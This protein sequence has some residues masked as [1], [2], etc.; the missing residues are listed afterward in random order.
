LSHRKK[1]PLAVIVNGSM[2]PVPAVGPKKNGIGYA[3]EMISNGISS[4]EMKTISYYDDN[5]DTYHFDRKK[6]IQIKPKFIHKLLFNFIF[7]IPLGIPKKLFGFSIA[8]RKSY[9]HSIGNTLKELEPDIIISQ[10]HYF[11]FNSLKK[12]YPNAKHVFH[13]RGSDMHEWDERRV[14][15]LFEKSDGIVTVC[16]A[17]MNSI[18]KKLNI[19]HEN[20]IVIPNAIDHKIFSKN[21]SIDRIK[22]IKSILSINLTDDIFLYA[23]RIHSS[24]G[25]YEVVEA[26]QMLKKINDKITLLIVGK[27]LSQYDDFELVEFLNQ[28][29]EN[30]SKTKIKIIETVDISKMA[31][32]YS[33][34]HISLSCSLE[35]EG[36]SKVIIE[37]L[38]SN[39]PVIVTD[40]GGN[41]EL[42]KHKYNGLIV[43]NKNLRKGLFNAMELIISDHK[44]YSHLA[45]NSKKSVIQ[46]HNYKRLCEDY[47]NYLNKLINK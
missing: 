5:L 30:Y 39:T 24:K 4:I 6:H 21:F 46:K 28:F 2:R 44:L 33:I 1:R 12:Y 42:V 26:F 15:D 8:K 45:K 35:H 40:V 14:Y 37:S 32:I 36:C 11:L 29:E 7:K 27:N 16:H 25:I 13:F 43:S 38:M 20:H 31:E 34:S 9:Y 18:T 3:I 19:S 17:A 41:P 10:T 23:G 47:E 22:K